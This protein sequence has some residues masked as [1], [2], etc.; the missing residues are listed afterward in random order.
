M[1]RKSNNKNKI[2]KGPKPKAPVFYGP[3]PRPRNRSAVSG[4]KSR[5]SVPRSA[6][7]TVCSTTDPFCSHAVGAK[8]MDNGSIKSLALTRHDRVTITTSTNGQWANMF[9]PSYNL[10]PWISPVSVI[11]SVADFTAAAGTASGAPVAAS[12][13]L[14]SMG[15]K[16]RSIVAPLSASGMVRIRGFGAQTTSTLANVDITTYNCDFFQDIPLNACKE[17][18]VNLKRVDP[19][20]KNFRTPSAINPDAVFTNMVCPGFGPVLISVDGGPVS[21]PVLDVETFQN[22]EITFPDSDALQ[23]AATKSPP[24]VQKISTVSDAISSSAEN[25]FLTGASAFGAYIE[26]NAIK[27]LSGA[28]GDLGGMALL[29]M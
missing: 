9:V 10:K 18:V 16:L 6:L 15:L 11:T 5:A 29:T 24:F 8:Y 19:T 21:L 2:A 14:V 4:A 7:A 23:Q 1:P 26:K 12:C 17:V 25:I 27:L 28:L 3:A 22:W 13:R 20:A